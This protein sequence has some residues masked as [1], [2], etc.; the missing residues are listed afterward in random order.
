[1]AKKKRKYTRRTPEQRIAALQAEIDR[2]RSRATEVDG[3]DPRSVRKERERLDLT[4]SQYGKLVGVAAMTIYGWEHGRS[5]PRKA[6]LELW[7]EV[8][9]LSRREAWKRLGMSAG[10]DSFSPDAVYEDRERLEL[11]RADYAELVGVSPLT[12]YNWE[13]GRTSP[14]AQQLECWLQAKGMGKREAWKRLELV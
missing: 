5:V 10:R 3:F 7:R 8:K 13:H 11:S 4:A 12:I 14:R 6:Q 2:I 1:M 9:G